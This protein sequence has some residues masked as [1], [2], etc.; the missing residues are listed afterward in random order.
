MGPSGQGATM[1]F[2]NGPAVFN[3]VANLTINGRLAKSSG[4][5]VSLAKLGSGIRHSA[6]AV[7]MYSAA[8]MSVAGR[9]F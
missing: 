3:T 8:R 1:L 2:N 5:L 6:E 4:G 9:L 7:T